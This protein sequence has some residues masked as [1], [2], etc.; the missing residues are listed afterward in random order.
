VVARKGTVQGKMKEEPIFRNTM[1]KGM[2][3]K[4]DGR[5]KIKM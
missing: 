1:S 3:D 2:G 5:V 4:R